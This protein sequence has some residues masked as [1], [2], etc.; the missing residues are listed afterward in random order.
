MRTLAI[1][2]TLRER[3]PVIVVDDG[4]LDGTPDAVRAWHSW[5]RLVSLASATGPS[6][7]NVGAE[8]AAT[9]LVAFADDDSWYEEGALAEAARIFAT[10]PRLALVAARVLVGP[11]RRLDPNCEAM[12]AEPLRGFLACGAI[13]RRDAFLAAGGFHPWMRTGGEEEYVSAQLA[14]RGWEQEYRP[15]V[16]AH[17][18]PP[19]RQDLSPRR[20][21][22]ARNA[23]LTELLLR[24]RTKAVA[25]A[26]KRAAGQPYP[27]DAVPG[28]LE[29]IAAGLWLRSNQ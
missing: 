12:A 25:R 11:K 16:I 24:P 2:G 22:L 21:A 26:L 19:H 13:V 20:R 14:A 5:V 23:A 10:R 1:F 8:V 4:S 29:G 3:P 18:W 28:A 9:P 15:E 6:A 7:R 27:H 17:H